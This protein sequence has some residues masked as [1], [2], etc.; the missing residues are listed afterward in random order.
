MIEGMSLG[1]SPRQPDMFAT[2]TSFCEG[3]VAEGSIYGLLHRECFALFPDELFADLFT[4]VGRRSVPPMI[5]AVVMVLQRLEGCSDR[6]AVDRFAFDVRWKYAAGGLD[7]DYPGFVHTVLVDMRA[8]LAGSRRPDRV[9]E[10]VLETAR[11][12]GLVGRRRVLDSTCLYDAVATMDTVTLVRSAVRGLLAVCPSGLEGELRGLLARDDDYVAAGKPVCD[13]DD[14][15][16]RDALV[17][18]LATDARALVGALDG[19]ELPGAVS[20]AAALLATVVGQ[21][22]DEGSDGA[23]RIARRVAKDRVIST[24][25]RDARHGR[26]TS[27]RGFDGYKGHVALDPDSELICATM[28]TAGNVGDGVGAADLLADDLPDPDAVPAEPAADPVPAEPAADAEP[29]PVADPEPAAGAGSAPGA[30]DLALIVYGDS[31]Y[32]AG[33]VL[34]MLEQADADIMCKVQA[35]VAA[36]GRYSKDAFQIDLPNGLVTC[37]A[38]HAAPMRPAAANGG[39]TVRFGEVCSGCPLA[40]RCTAAKTGRTIYIGPYEQQLARART[41]Q[42]DPAWKTDYTATRP[43]VERKIGHLMRREHGGRRARMRG[44]DKVGADFSLLAAA[45]NLARLAVLGLTNS[46]GAWAPNPA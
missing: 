29:E 25:D 16:E 28:V 18:A 14:K 7:F 35:P 38:G 2:T 46:A 4:S 6:E 39:R 15:A 20:E 44:E 24:V 31:A 22:L 19:R 12:A 8:R 43:K 40:E 1:L 21:D 11:Q 3:R 27:A 41:R 33:A 26:K 42:A 5:V 32:G 34:D 37:P 23:F 17:D 36:G 9:F 10:V 13:Y 45:T 30:G